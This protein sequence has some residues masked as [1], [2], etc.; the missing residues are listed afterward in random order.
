MFSVAAAILWVNIVQC[1]RDKNN[2]NTLLTAMLGTTIN[3]AETYRSYLT[4][5]EQQLS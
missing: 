4:D 3:N 1:K 2:C 5:T